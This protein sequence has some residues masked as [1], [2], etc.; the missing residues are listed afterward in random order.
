MSVF[1]TLKGTFQ[2]VQ[3][4][5]VDGLKALTSLDSAPRHERYKQL[6][7]EGISLDAGA[8]L[9]LRYQKEWSDIQSYTTESAKKAEEI[10]SVVGGLFA[11]C[12]KQWTV[13]SQLEEE[14]ATLPNILSTINNIKQLMGSL[15]QD[16]QAVEEELDRLENICEEQALVKAKA[17]HMAQLA[18]YRKNKEAEAHGVKA[19][20][21]A[22]LRERAREMD[23]KKS[24][25]LIERQ[26]AFQDAFSSDMDYYRT[27]G[28]PDRLPSGA[29]FPKV[30]SLS[31]ITIEEDSKALD[32]FLSSGDGD[33]AG[34]F[35]EDD[36]TTD[37]REKES[38]DFPELDIGIKVDDD[39]DVDVD[40]AGATNNNTVLKDV[41]EPDAG[42]ASS[43]KTPEVTNGLKEESDASEKADDKG[44]PAAASSESTEGETTQEPKPEENTQGS[45]SLDEEKS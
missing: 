33:S 15:Q 16:F 45:A 7:A 38:E 34:A 18:D 3:Q 44:L 29:E 19:K 40:A 36:Y 8:D 17:S 27:H 31:D 26:E 37:Y 2:N 32:E 23:A 9:L 22:M 28:R 39:L 43:G 5:I 12:E 11:R 42:D 1:K 41:E 20:L 4:D 25:A 35:I 14:A 21:W 6:K 10:D 13:A 30:S 24:H